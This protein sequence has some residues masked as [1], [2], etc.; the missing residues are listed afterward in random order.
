MSAQNTLGEYTPDEPA[1]TSWSEE[2]TEL[3]CA[4]CAAPVAIN[5]SYDVYYQCEQ[6]HVQRAAL[7]PDG[8]RILAS[9]LPADRF[10]LDTEL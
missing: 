10:T 9:D 6:G 1:R 3:V 7:G 8:A 2:Y 5:V 4:R